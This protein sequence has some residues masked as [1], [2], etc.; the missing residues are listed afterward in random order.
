MEISENSDEF[1][2]A[3]W[4]SALVAMHSDKFSSMYQM[5]VHMVIH[6]K[7]VSKMPCWRFWWKNLQNIKNKNWFNLA[8]YRAT[9]WNSKKMDGNGRLPF[10][11]TPY[12]FRFYTKDM[13]I[14]LMRDLKSPTSIANIYFKQHFLPR[15]ERV[16]RAKN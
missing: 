7:T 1:L 8:L 16:G 10:V 5:F 4:Q 2:M 11:H 15:R 13:N 9:L 14:P 3:A 12:L 6:R